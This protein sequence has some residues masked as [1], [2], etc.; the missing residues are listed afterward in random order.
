MANLDG[1]RESN[2]TISKFWHE[3][4]HQN[5]EIL[6]SHVKVTLD[7]DNDG[8]SIIMKSS[9]YQF[10]TLYLFYSTNCQ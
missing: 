8:Y 2:F 7:D 10:L 9:V 1:V 4:A 3:K 6:L 5:F